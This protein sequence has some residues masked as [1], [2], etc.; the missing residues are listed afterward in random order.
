[1]TTKKTNDQSR[2]VIPPPNIKRVVATIEGTT[3]YVQNKFSEKARN[4]IREAQEAGSTARK[5]KKREPKDFQKACDAA[6]HVSTEGWYGIPAAAFRCAMIDACRLVGFKMTIA[7]CSLVTIAD[8]FDEDE[9]GMVKI[10][11]G[12]PKMSVLPVPLPASG[13]MDLRARPM[14]G[15]GWQANVTIEFDADQFQPV[16]VLNLLIRAGRQIGVG[17]GRPFSK[18]SAGCGW[19]TFRVLEEKS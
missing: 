18:N 2:I 16:D 6:L 19:G 7:K 17:E 5:G 3:P 1:M 11:K 13:T 12:E 4:A 8:G 9:T 14:W 10:T 15:P